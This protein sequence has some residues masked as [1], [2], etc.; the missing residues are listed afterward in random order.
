MVSRRSMQLVSRIFVEESRAF[1]ASREARC[2]RIATGI[3]ASPVIYAWGQLQLLPR[4]EIHGGSRALFTAN[5]IEPCRCRQPTG[6]PRS[7]MDHR[8][9]RLGLQRR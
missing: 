9:Q 7:F 4:V 1:T 8:E 6:N 3:Q 5:P 2:R